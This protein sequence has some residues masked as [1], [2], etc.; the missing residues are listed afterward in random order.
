MVIVASSTTSTAAVRMS[1]R[2][3]LH[4]VTKTHHTLPRYASSSSA[5][6]ASLHRALPRPSHNDMGRIPSSSRICNGCLFYTRPMTSLS[7]SLLP[8]HEHNIISNRPIIIGQQT[9]RQF[10]SKRK[11][12]GRNNKTQKIDENA[13]LLNE[14]LVAE[15]FNE[16]NKKQGG[17]AKVSPDTFQVRLII[18]AGR[19]GKKGNDDGNNESSNSSSSSPSNIESRIVT[20]NE[21]INIS[22]ELSLDLIGVTLKQDPPVIKEVDYDKWLY[23]QKKKLSKKEKEIKKG[24]GSGG[25][26]SDRPLKE[27]KFRAGIADHD[28]ERKTNNML[29]YLGKGHA[30]RVTLTARQRSLNADAQA[31]RTTLDRVKELIGDRAVEARGMKANDRLS[32]GNLLFHPNNK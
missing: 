20:V 22:H 10:A 9:N 31:I 6:I 30:I 16:I 11:Q 12:K 1:N 17:A 19:D 23:D 18:D 3:L 14:H 28:L 29:K 2:L 5:S 26:I 4:C 27:F 7:S 15:L 24:S 8:S 21:A 32:Y 25:A 13:P